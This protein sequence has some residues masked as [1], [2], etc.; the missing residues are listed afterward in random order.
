MSLRQIVYVS[1]GCHEY[2]AAKLEEI[3]EVGRRN[4][5]NCGV[6]GILLH[7]SGNFLQL[8]EGEHAAVGA[9]YARIVADP[10]HTGILKLQDEEIPQRQFPDYRL[11]FR[12]IAEGEMTTCPELF[13]KFNSV[14]NVKPDSGIDPKL[15]VLFRT[16]FKINGGSPA[17]G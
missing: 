3:T 7:Y 14:W 4:N 11:A 2:S 12:S 16:F 10:R 15:L 5:R 8:L 1:S 9:T 6:T 13:E 17:R